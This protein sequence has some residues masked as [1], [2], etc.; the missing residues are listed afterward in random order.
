MPRRAARYLSKR[1][2]VAAS[3]DSCK[4]LMDSW[5]KEK[6]ALLEFMAMD[7]ADRDLAANR[8]EY[9]EFLQY[10]LEMD[11]EIFASYVGLADKSY[12]FSDE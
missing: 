7:A 11:S 9:L 8:D 4:N 1:Q 10:S 12:L 2:A 3:V 5:F 6:I